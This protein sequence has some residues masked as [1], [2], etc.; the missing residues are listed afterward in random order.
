MHL[1]KRT[2]A[3][4]LTFALCAETLLGGNAA[5]AVALSPECAPSQQGG[6]LFA[7]AEID[8]ATAVDADADSASGVNA[9][10]GADD[11]NSSG[12]AKASVQADPMPS[13]PSGS[14]VVDA[15][16]ASGAQSIPAVNI[17]N[18]SSTIDATVDVFWA[19]VDD[20][21]DDIFDADDNRVWTQDASQYKSHAA[22]TKVRILRNGTDV[23]EFE[24]TGEADGAVHQGLIGGDAFTWEEIAPWRVFISGLPERDGNDVGYNYLLLEEPASGF[25]SINVERGADAENGSLYTRFCNAR[26]SAESNGTVVPLSVRWA[27]GGDTASRVSVRVGLYANRDIRIGD[28]IG[29]YKDGRIATKDLSEGGFWYGEINVPVGGLDVANDFYISELSTYDSGGSD[30]RGRYKVVSRD[31]ALRGADAG[32]TEY[33]ALLRNWPEN[34]TASR[35]IS[36]DPNEGFAYRVTY[37]R[38]NALGSLEAVNQRIGFTEVAISRTWLDEGADESARPKSTFALV[39]PSS[40][41]EF[42]YNAAGEVYARVSGQGDYALYKKDASGNLAP[43][44]TSPDPSNSDITVSAARDSLIMDESAISGASAFSIV[45]LPKYDAQGAAINW[46]VEQN[47]IG[48]HGDYQ[49]GGGEATQTA[50]SPWH[51]EDQLTFSFVNRREAT[52]SISLRTVFAGLVDGDKYP[53]STFKL[54]RYRDDALGE[55]ALEL[56]TQKI[57]TAADAAAGELVFDNLDVYTPT[58]AKWKYVVVEVAPDGYAATSGKGDLLASDPGFKSSA[59]WAADNGVALPAE[60]TTAWVM[61]PAIELFEDGGAVAVTFRNMRVSDAATLAGKVHWIDQGNEL[62]TRPASVSLKL[63]RAYQDGTPAGAIELQTS[64]SSAPNYLVWTSRPNNGDVWTY[65]VQNLEKWAPDGKPWK[66]T[67]TENP[68]DS[69]YQ[70]KAGTDN[71]GSCDSTAGEF[72]SIVNE[73]KRV[74]PGGGS[75]Q[76]SGGADDG[77]NPDASGGADNPGGSDSPG[78]SGASDDAGGFDDS[79]ASGDASGS[80]DSGGDIALP[81][82]SSGVSASVAD[83]QIAASA[84]P[85]TGDYSLLLHSALAC[86]ALAAL[87]LSLHRLRSDDAG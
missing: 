83:G 23:A 48:E 63:T 87:A 56:A 19:S 79:E 1:L 35:M 8:A 45:N 16:S 50:V 14:E 31:D 25:V 5:A 66:Y 29:Y 76:G 59:E 52:K 21:G 7:K 13:L 46:K 72:P 12:S 33:A 58:G 61:S 60:A 3:F 39:S 75:D 9:A 18:A 86:L 6:Q 64:D 85:A 2:M 15:D 70:I 84:V 82:E 22:S 42:V 28:L 26:G 44:R 57:L 10:A 77:D 67:V 54:Y 20:E 74:A 40:N 47:W 62:G 81:E 55:S 36:A 51:Q 41:V 43:L 34:D 27:D 37:E 68:L 17:V 73:L 30:T 4:V 11:A 53:D 69:R 49:I 24:L 71:G 78:D 80:G 32:N 65:E 38:N